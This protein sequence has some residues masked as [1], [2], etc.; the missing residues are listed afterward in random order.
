MEQT[1]NKDK[2]KFLRKISIL[3]TFGSLLFGYDSG[4]IN[5]ALTFIARKDQLNLTP[6]TEGLVTSSLLL[7]AAIGAVLMGHF[8][9]KYGRKKVLKVLAAVFF[10]STIGCSISPNAEII[11]I[12]RFIVGIGV[13]GVSVVVPT[14][15]AEMAPT[16]IRG[17]LV[18]R[19]QFMIVTG[20]LLAYIFNGILGN[21]FENPG[22]WRYMIAIS[23][24]PAVVLWFGMLVVPETPRWLASHGKIADALEILR[25]TRE[26]QE[27][28]AEIKEIQKNIEAESSLERATFKELGIPWIRRIVIIGCLIAIIQQFAGVNVLMYYGTTVLEKSG[29]GVKT[30]LIANIG[31]GIMSVVASW[32]YMHLLSNRC[33]RRP[34][35]IIGYCGTTVTWLAITIVSHVLSGS[36]TLPFVI[37]ILT[38]IFLAIDQA[39]LGPLTWLLLS[40]IFPLRVRGMGYGV[41][42]FFNWI[43]NF[44]VGLTFPILIAYFGLSS[45]FL[46][47]VL[48]GVL[49]IICAIMVVPETRGKSLEQM[50]DYFRSYK[51][52]S[53]S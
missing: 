8:S 24:I 34:L 28:E 2:K 21:V 13:G 30:A 26:E 22:I 5:G 35:L 12:C 46:I 20:Q 9:D 7:G 4:V 45:T 49:C 10:F 47:F 39:T 43:G 53:E 31:N 27:A 52:R 40:E 38:M 29:F 37:V 25:Q 42:T 15:L 44:A 1:V 23:S 19:D 11:I 51:T 18:S 6:L 16:K 33:N 48:L 14:L 3:A 50:E 17:S 36:G 32:I 41:A